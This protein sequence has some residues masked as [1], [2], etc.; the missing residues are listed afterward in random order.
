EI[1]PDAAQQSYLSGKQQDLSYWL[2]F[3]AAILL[4]ADCIAVLWMAGALRIGR[5]KTAVSSFLVTGLGVLLLSAAQ[6]P[7]A[8]AQDSSFDFS[9]TLKTRLAYVVT[10][11]ADID[12]VS[13]A[14]MRGLTLYLASR[15]ALEPGEPIGVDVASDELSFYSL[16][17]W[18]IDPAA[19]FPSAA[20]MARVDAYMKEGGSILFDTRDQLSGPFGGTANSPASI[21]LQQMLS[22]LDIPALEPVPED[23]VLTKSFYLL[24]EFPGRYAG[25]DLWVQVSQETQ[26]DEGRPARVGDGVSSIMIT[27]ND[28]AGAWAVD[29]RSTPLYQT[30]PPDPAQRNYAFRAGVNLM[31]YALTGNYKSDQVHLPAL[32]ERLGQ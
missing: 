25:G 28:F 16:L 8:H 17:Y 19:D 21:A 6:L 29:Q 13:E 32:L 12:D 11:I 3:T 23:H 5:L 14:G 26:E 10:G 31:M 9:S 22:T 18:P 24:D 30:V 4:I 20:T 27:S 7:S 15:T 2:L 1:L